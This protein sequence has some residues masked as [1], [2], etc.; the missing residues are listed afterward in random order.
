MINY[1]EVVFNDKSDLVDPRS[2]NTITRLSDHEN[3]RNKIILIYLLVIN[4]SLLYVKRFTEEAATISTK[5]AV[6]NP[7][8]IYINPEYDV[9]NAC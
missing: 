5:S 9:S 3:K 7:Y 2:L 4:D 6:C 1:I 8:Y